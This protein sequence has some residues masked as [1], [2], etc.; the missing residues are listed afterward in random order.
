MTPSIRE[1][2]P[3]DI[4]ALHRALSALSADLGDTHRATEDNL[5]KALH[6]PA[7]FAAA[8]LAER[9]TDPVGAALFSPVFSTTGGGPGA[10]VTDLWVASS[11]RGTGLGRGLLACTARSAAARWGAAYL[12]LMVYEDNTDAAAFYRRLGF[13]LEGRE[14]PARL[15]G[16]A[17]AALAGETP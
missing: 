3:G 7:A 8:T 15:S 1:A 12:S 5:A 14:R 16:R 6:G 9:G 17:F 4:A 13:A 11:E 2:G 10:Y